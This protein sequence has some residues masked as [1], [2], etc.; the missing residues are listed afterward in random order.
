MLS[1]DLW[2]QIRNAIVGP[3]GEDYIEALEHERIDDL[4]YEEV[5]IPPFTA[6]G[7]NAKRNKIKMKQWNNMFFGIEHLYRIT[8]GGWSMSGMSYQPVRYRDEYYRNGIQDFRYFPYMICVPNGVEFNTKIAKV[9][10]EKS[11]DKV[12]CE[13]DGYNAAAG[14]KSQKNEYFE[15]TG[16]MWNDSLPIHFYNETTGTDPIYENGKFT[17]YYWF[18]MHRIGPFRVLIAYQNIISWGVYEKDGFNASTKD[19]VIYY[20]MVLIILSILLYLFLYVAK[21]SNKAE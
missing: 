5:Q 4:E 10:I 11:L 20:G 6:K 15:I 8:D 3:N 14:I 18:G 21:H 12:Y 17:D 2:S 16:R 1:S 9:I 13:P 7:T 19:R